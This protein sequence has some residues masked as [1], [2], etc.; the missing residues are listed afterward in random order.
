[1]DSAEVLARPSPA[2]ARSIVDTVARSSFPTSSFQRE[3]RVGSDSDDD[4]LGSS[5]DPTQWFDTPANTPYLV[6]NDSNAPSSIV[7]PSAPTFYD[8]DADASPMAFV[9]DDD[10]LVPTTPRVDVALPVPPL[11]AIVPVVETVL[12]P[13][14]PPRPVEVRSRTPRRSN[15]IRRAPLK[16]AD[17]FANFSESELRALASTAIE[18]YVTSTPKT[19]ARAHAC[20]ALMTILDGTDVEF[21]LSKAKVEKSKAKSKSKPKSKSKADPDT[22]TY[23]EVV[24]ASDRTKFYDAMQAEWRELMSFK[25]F[26]LVLKRDVLKA[27]GNIV[28]STWAFRRKRNQFTGEI[29]R[30]K[31]RLCLRGDLEQEIKEKYAPVGTWST[32]RQMLTLAAR[33]GLPTR[34]IDISN[35]FVQAKLKTPKY[36]SIPPG[37]HHLPELLALVPEGVDIKD[38][39]LMVHRSL[40]GGADA[41]KLF[42][43]LCQDIFINKMGMTP[44]TKDPCLFLGD[45]IAVSCYVDD[46]FIVA[47]DQAKIDK[48]IAA[49]IEAGLPA[50]DE[51]EIS[52]YLGITIERD[53]KK[54]TFLLTQPHL[55]SRL[56]ETVGLLVNPKRT[57]KKLPALSSVALGPHSDDEDFAEDWD[58]RSAIGMLLF[59]SNNSRPEIAFSVSQAARY[60]SNP[61][62]SHGIAVKRIVR[63]LQDTEDDGLLMKPDTHLAIDAY[64]DSDF[65]GTWKTVPSSNPDSVKSRAGFVIC[66]GGCPLT[67]CSK[68]ISEICMSTMMAE[69]IALSMCMRELIPLR[70]VSAELCAALHLNAVSARTHSVIFEDNNGAL[71]LATGPKDTP[72]SKF[73]AVKYHW[74][75]EQVK[76]GTCVI[77][78]I[79][80]AENVA[81]IFTKCDA[82]LFFEMRRRLMGF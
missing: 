74:F 3:S 82:K 4:S 22:L 81:D 36:M 17:E 30:H 5:F 27:N 63:Y 58:Y 31:A 9:D 33:Y 62:K 43:E 25:T 10:P 64:V 46:H 38:C 14:V 12:E 41:P 66:L 52:Q 19:M 42:F 21:D 32:I 76:N 24:K 35:A 71:S 72:H 13:V 6:R 60:S 11:P 51:G 8:S 78:K 15:R 1:M 79:A 39:C 26:T 50:N 56:I 16:Y 20:E 40:Y 57:K 18:A 49:L 2:V 75:R 70:I 37:V 59:L 7:E 67:W 34:C 77:K 80:S 53:L 69:Y 48:Y 54:K 68:L 61:K 65:A 55:I 29:K 28:P 45:G 23:W 44:C 73:Y 47:T